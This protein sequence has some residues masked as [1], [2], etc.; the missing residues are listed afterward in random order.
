LIV[1]AQLAD[2]LPDWLTTAMLLAPVAGLVLSVLLGKK[3]FAEKILACFFLYSIVFVA[4][5]SGSEVLGAIGCFGF[6]ILSPLLGL[7]FVI[8]PPRRSILSDEP[9]P[10]GFPVILKPPDP[11]S[12]PPGE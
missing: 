1:L 10:P 11:S 3:G 9:G 7:L 2:L 5:S 6:F 4:V 12:R 8:L